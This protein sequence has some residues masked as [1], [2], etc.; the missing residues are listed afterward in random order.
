[1]V[2][3][4]V[5]Q[6]EI[7]ALLG[8]NGAGKSTLMKILAG[9]Y[10]VE[11]GELLIEGRPVSFKHPREALQVGIGTVYQDLRL[12]PQ[13]SVAD[14]IFLG[15]EAGNGF[16]INERASVQRAESVLSSFGVKNIDV[17]ARVSTLPL[18]QQQLVEIAK[19]LSHN[20]RILIMDEPTAALA[21]EETS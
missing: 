4:G 13:L 12:V 21:E 15:R 14:N 7:H 19:V 8:Q 17:R 1:H 6:G 2:D 10:P 11:E 16:V 3:F 5:R 20:P 9:V 18:A